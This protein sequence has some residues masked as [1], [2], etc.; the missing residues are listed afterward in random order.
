MLTASSQPRPSRPERR[1]SARSPCTDGTVCLVTDLLDQSVTEAGVWNAGP[2]GLCL[3]IEAPY[4]TGDRL[5]L[6]LRGPKGVARPGLVAEVVY[7]LELPSR[8]ELW[9]TG[10]AYT[11][12]SPTG[13]ADAPPE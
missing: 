12:S 4:H 1:S 2:G 13:G 8:R 3:V 5:S 11:D 6:E 7:A 10:C 9:M